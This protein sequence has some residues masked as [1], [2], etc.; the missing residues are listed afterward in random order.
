MTARAKSSSIE[1]P[2]NPNEEIAK[3]GALL[4]TLPT[5]APSNRNGMARRSD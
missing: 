4:I 3:A 5:V 1:N 2:Q